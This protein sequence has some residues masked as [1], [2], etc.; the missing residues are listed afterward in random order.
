MAPSLAA[1]A[2]LRQDQLR[3]SP[4]SGDAGAEVEELAEEPLPK[5]R[6]VDSFGSSE[7]HQGQVLMRA[8]QPSSLSFSGQ[9]ARLFCYI[10]LLVC[11]DAIL[12]SWKWLIHTAGWQALESSYHLCSQVCVETLRRAI[13]IS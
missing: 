5:R 2:V 3:P 11:V 7:S 13:H 6:W 9:L 1:L 8:S 10:T 12:S 4:T